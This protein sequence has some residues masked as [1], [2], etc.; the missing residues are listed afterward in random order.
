LLSYTYNGWQIP[1]ENFAGARGGFFSGNGGNRFPNNNSGAAPAGN[2]Q[3]LQARPFNGRLRS[4]GMM[5]DN[6]FNE[7]LMNFDDNFSQMQAEFDNMQRNSDNDITLQSNGGAVG[8]GKSLTRNLNESLSFYSGGKQYSIIYS[9]DNQKLTLK[10]GDLKNYLD[11]NNNAKVSIRILDYSNKVLGEYN[12]PEDFAKN[13]IQ[14]GLNQGQ[15][16]LMEVS[17]LD[18]NGNQVMQVNQGI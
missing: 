10:T 3:S 4:M 14:V 17:V 6:F 8:D 18:E 9:A 2:R 1:G 5:N 11:V 12:K 13:E 16:Y 15:N 7:P